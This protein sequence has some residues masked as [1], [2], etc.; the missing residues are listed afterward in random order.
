MLF[1]WIAV[2]ILSSVKSLKALQEKT[3]TLGEPVTLKCDMSYHHEIYWVKL[4]ADYQP[5]TVMV[6][7]L[8]NDGALSVAW[9]SNETHYEGCV[10]ERLIGLKISKVSERDLAMY[11]CAASIGKPMEFGEGVRLQTKETQAPSKQDSETSSGSRGPFNT[12]IIIAGALSCGLLLMVVTIV[13]V[14][15]MTNRKRTGM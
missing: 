15:V 9:N 4:G 10:V 12:H 2:L 3:V 6:M 5:K 8:K 7:G 11:F 14:H 1:A 13:A